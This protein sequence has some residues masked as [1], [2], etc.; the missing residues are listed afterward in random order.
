MYEIASDIEAS[1]EEKRKKEIEEFD[2]KCK[3]EFDKKYHPEKY[4]DSK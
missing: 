2:K 3:D 4:K 1:R